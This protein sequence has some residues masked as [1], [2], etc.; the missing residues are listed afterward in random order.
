MTDTPAH[1]H[2][3]PY[4]P[5]PGEFRW[6]DFRDDPPA[7]PAADV[8]ADDEAP[9]PA[10]SAQV[11]DAFR[12]TAPPIPTRAI[13]RHATSM[14]AFR[15]EEP[16]EDDP[17]LGFA[18]VPHK[19]L[20]R[21][22]IGPDRQRAFIAHLAATGIVAHAAR[23]I[24]ASTEALYNLRKRAGGEE[25]DQAW[26]AALDR[27][28]ERLEEA[29][30]AR[31]IEGV[32]RLI[33]SGG[34]VLGTERRHNEGLVMFLLRQRRPERYGSDIRPG[35]PLYER[36]RAEVLAGQ[37]TEE[38]SEDE[39]FAAIDAKLARIRE[40]HDMAARLLEGPSF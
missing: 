33:V 23:H 13:A 17:L 18:P 1:L 6:E 10:A 8:S 37:R 36:I 32:E 39:N 27:G 38:R 22:S 12:R 30:I 4:I 35:H 20:R 28:V 26:D 24:G 34:K 9:P 25:F 11:E 21:N 14:M 29:A 7:E 19:Q 5:T 31:A 15:G 2:D 40:S 16:G 3:E